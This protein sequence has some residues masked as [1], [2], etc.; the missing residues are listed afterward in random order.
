[1]KK[2]KIKEFIIYGIIILIGV[3]CFLLL[4]DNAERYNQW[5]AQQNERFN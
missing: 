2:E 4:S 3:G 1:M 5:E